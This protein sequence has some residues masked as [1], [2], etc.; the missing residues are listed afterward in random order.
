M[1][2]AVVATNENRIVLL[3]LSFIHPFLLNALAVSYPA[4]LNLGKNEKS[5][6]SSARISTNEN[7]IHLP[8]S[9]YNDVS[10]TFLTYVKRRSFCNQLT[11]VIFFLLRI[12]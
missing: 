9:S 1:T 3:P 7:T 10:R 11:N 4:R 8:N 12:E 5:R 6:D 2:S